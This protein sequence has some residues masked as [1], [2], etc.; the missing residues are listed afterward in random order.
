MKSLVI[1]IAIVTSFLFLGC[2]NDLVDDCSSTLEINQAIG[3]ETQLLSTALSNYGTDQSQENCDSV[4][5]AYNRYIDALRSLQGCANA[6][7]VGT[8]FA[9]SLTEAESS[10]DDFGC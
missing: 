4:V 6:A 7:G 9:Q 1:L 10:L 5:D 3:T 8:D 2:G